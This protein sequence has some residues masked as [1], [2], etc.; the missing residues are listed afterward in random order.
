[1]SHLKFKYF[2]AFIAMI[3]VCLSSCTNSPVGKPGIYINE[4]LCSNSGVNVSPLTNEQ[5]DW[6]ELYNNYDTAVN[7]SGYFLSDKEKDTTRWVFPSGTILAPKEYQIVWADRLDTLLHTNYKLSRKGGSISLYSADKKLLDY[8][9]YF[10]QDVNVSYGRK[11]DGIEQW[12]YFDIPTPSSSNAKQ[13]GVEQLIYSEDP[14]FSMNAGF[15]DSEQILF[16]SCL[17]D[18]VDLRYTLDG[19]IPD[20][21]STRYTDPLEIYTTSVVRVISIEKGKLCSRP[22]TKTY[23][24][25]ETKKDMPIISL[26]SDQE[27]LWDSVS[28]IYEN[29]L[30]GL[31]RLANIE[32]FEDRKQVV[33]QEVDIKISGNWARYFDQKAMVIAAKSKYGKSTMDYQFFPNKRNYY[34]PS[35]LLRA[36]GHPDKYLTTI[37]DGLGLSL[38]D[39]Y[40]GIDH[41]GY[42]PTVV[43]LN[44]KYWGIYNIREKINAD[45]IASNNNLDKK[46]FDLIQD[47]WLEVKNGDRKHYEKTLEFI[48]KC[49]KTKPSNYVKAKKIIDVNNFIDYTICELYV[50]NIDWPNWNIK[51]WREKTDEAKWRWILIDL[52]FGF[53]SGAKVDFNMIE[54]ATSPFMSHKQ[55]K[56]N[57]PRATVMLRKLLEFPEFRKDFIQR[58][59]V[60][61]NVIYST[62]RILTI[63]NKFTD[64]KVNEMPAHLN[65][66]KSSFYP[67]PWTPGLEFSIPSSMEEWDKNINLIRVFAKKRP[68]IIRKN[69]MKKFNIDGTVKIKTVAN[70]GH[71]EINTINLEE[72]TQEANYFIKIPMKMEAIP[73]LGHKFLYWMV[74]GRKDHSVNLEFMPLSDGVIEAVFEKGTGSI[75]PCTITENKTLTA[76][77]SPYYV[78]CDVVVDKGA[79]LVIEKGVEILME[80]HR[81]II[82]HGGLMC[83]G[84]EKHPISILPNPYTKTKEIGAIVVENASSKV[85]LNHVHISHGTWQHDKLKYKG[86]ITAI[87]S[88][89]S[90]DHVTV[91]SAHFPFYSE[92]GNVAIRNSRLTSPKACDIINIKY[93]MNALVEGCDLPGNDYPNTDAIDYDQIKDGVIRNNTIYGF[94]GFNSDAIDIGEASSNIL[95][96]GNKIFNISD[97]GVSVG[98]GASAIIRN[99]F[100]Y[101]CTMGVGIKDLNSHAIIEENTFYG[102]KYGVAVFEK[103]INAGGGTAE[104]KNCIFSQ[105]KKKDV[106]LDTLSQV[107]IHYSLS[108]KEELVGEG[109]VYADPEFEDKLTFNFSLNENSPARKGNQVLGANVD[110]QRQQTPG[111]IINEISCSRTGL[112]GSNDWV[113]IYNNSSADVDLTGWTIKNEKHHS[114]TFPQHFTLKKN[115]Y[116]VITNEQDKLLSRFPEVEN[117]KENLDKRIINKGNVLLMYDAHMNLVDHVAY[118]S[119]SLWPENLREEGVLIKLKSPDL[120]NEKETNWSVGETNSDTPGANNRSTSLSHK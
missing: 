45:F 36:G 79:T 69:L 85:V 22:I 65:R 19:S 95:V 50:A 66:W 111:I 24:I 88:D 98:Q 12:V 116:F 9:D 73:N 80:K 2:T 87:N 99:N 92:Y 70:K 109:N 61:L 14:M 110:L 38:S 59:A 47:S 58:F 4:I 91:E 33:N 7:I 102:N 48:K 89:I 43:Y 54:F 46:K 100:I 84:T 75:I 120:A 78:Q 76:D 42:R 68:D 5:A 21:N 113:E 39:E 77:K 31:D 15:Y 41:A 49:D 52:D 53:G 106:M 16:L 60:S 10:P 72:G 40:S 1:M 29:S 93:A 119:M 97:K 62:E 27:A 71:I 23:F 64:E 13:T 101:G 3:Y 18:D 83:N 104:I 112:N 115:E 118:K 103:N 26:V 114:Y 34:F 11:W 51:F 57:P 56:T 32:F 117:V 8:V 20:R 55:K 30:R 108:D 82:V 35:I 81:S 25:N 86:T 37:R 17:K 44:G 63:V 94:S 28:G 6:I 67:D 90:L 107:S 105:S 96:E 74:N